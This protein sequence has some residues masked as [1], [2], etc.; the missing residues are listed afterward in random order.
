MARY[1]G[2]SPDDPT[3]GNFK[4]LNAGGRAHG[5]ECYNFADRRGRYFGSHPGDVGTNI[6][7]LGGKPGAECVGNVLVVWFSKDPR[8]DK[9]VIVGW[10]RNATVYRKVHAPK[11][12]EGHKLNGDVIWYKATA[13]EADCTCLDVP[14]RTF[15]IPSRSQRPGGYGQN[16]NWY[17]LGETFLDSVWLYVQQNGIRLGSGRHKGTG[18]PF[19]N[20][21][22]AKRR[23]VEDTAIRVAFEFYESPAGGSR[24]VKSVELEAKGWDLEAKGSMDELL[25]EVKGLSGEVPIAEL[26]PNEYAKMRQH[27]G[28]WVLFVVTHCLSRK[29]RTYQFRYMHDANRW[30]TDCGKILVIE[31]KVAAIVRA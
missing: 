12:G 28:F 26:T 1:A 21:D 4:W 14:Q 30:E 19:R 27:K 11:A 2:P 3:R 7:K 23:M 9:A 5:H 6:E 25:V 10:Y 29:P 17:G 8:T 16:P 24:T 31:E 20:T 22:H 18:H 15:P 13:A